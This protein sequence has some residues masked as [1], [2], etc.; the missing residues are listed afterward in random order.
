MREIIHQKQSNL[1]C[2]CTCIAMLA[3]KP[4]RE[5]VKRFHS[6]YLIEN[7]MNVSDILWE[8]QIP[9]RECRQ[10]EGIVR[11]KL[12]IASVPSL[13]REG[14][15]HLIIIDFRN[16]ALK[17]YDPNQGVTGRRYYVTSET[18]KYKNQVTFHGY[19][20]EYEVLD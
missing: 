13:N 17:L 7:T 16:N 18:P 20:V 1:D 19:S 2:V 12:Y 5:I 15:T 3:G 14:W 4:R 10:E 6:K 8:L 11:G 9:F